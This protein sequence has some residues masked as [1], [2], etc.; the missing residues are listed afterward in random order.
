MI[1]F[2]RQNWRTT[3]QKFCRPNVK[4]D[5]RP[6]RLSLNCRRAV[7]GW[8]E[9]S[10]L[11]IK[12][13]E[14]VWVSVFFNERELA[15]Q[16]LPV[17]KGFFL[18]VVTWPEFSWTSI[19]CFHGFL[20]RSGREGS[21]V[22]A[23]DHALSFYLCNLCSLFVSPC[24]PESYLQ[25]QTKTEPVSMYCKYHIIHSPQGFSGIIYNT[26]WGTLSDCLTCSLRVIKERVMM[27]PYTSV[28]VR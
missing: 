24:P 16:R 10:Y 3:P 28:K 6:T 4:D 15:L 7:G 14:I 21:L 8:D 1:L 25:T 17:T 9:S 13:K 11:L 2:S 5:K 22:V 19:N 20:R 23:C 27:P 18:F 12:V 26:G